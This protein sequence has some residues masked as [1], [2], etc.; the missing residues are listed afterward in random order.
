MPAIPDHLPWSRRQTLPSLNNLPVDHWPAPRIAP[1][2]ALDL[3][4]SIQATT[5]GQLIWRL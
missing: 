3:Q 4:A 1:L 2:I 5:P